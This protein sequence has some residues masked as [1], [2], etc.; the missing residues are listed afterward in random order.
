MKA[1]HRG[2]REAELENQT[3]WTAK[4][5]VHK[6]DNAYTRKEKHKQRYFEFC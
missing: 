3:G 2:S 5:K 1:I 6:S 4:H